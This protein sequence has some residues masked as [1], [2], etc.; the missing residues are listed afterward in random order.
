MAGKS[1][2]LGGCWFKR[3]GADEWE[4]GTMYAFVPHSQGYAA[5]ASAAADGHILVIPLNR[6]IVVG[7]K[8]P[9]DEAEPKGRREAI[10]HPKAVLEAAAPHG[11]HEG[12][13]R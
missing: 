2:S 1:D 8:K 12:H 7:D 11:G 13:R 10:E 6:S 3:D 9:E 5:I 4:E